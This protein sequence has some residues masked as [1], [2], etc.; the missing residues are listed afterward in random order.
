MIDH[1]K[2]PRIFLLFALALALT[3]ATFFN[4][5][6][7]RMILLSFQ[8]DDKPVPSGL[9]DHGPAPQPAALPEGEMTKYVNVIA[10]EDYIENIFYIGDQ[11]VA[12]F[13]E[14]A[15]GV[16]ERTGI[17]PEGDIKVFYSQSA[18]SGQEHY[19]GGLREGWAK[20][21]FQDGQVKTETYYRKDRVLRQKE[22]H[23]NGVMRFEVDYSDAW[24]LPGQK[25]IGVGKLYYPD[26]ILKYEWNFTVSS[27][28]GHRKSYNQDGSLRYAAYY[29]SS[30]ELIREEKGH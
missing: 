23:P 14:N 22:Y 12:R 15:E 19:E 21:H 9:S 17:P 11:E 24:D 1:L 30:G 6:V 4:I 27:P 28:A 2:E 10:G 3:G 7:E 16:F 18:T 25:E 13:K 20:T 8:E 5:W 26:G 29:N